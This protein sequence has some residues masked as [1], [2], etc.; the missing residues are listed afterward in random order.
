M[1]DTG[2]IPGEGLPENAGMVEQPGIPA[3]GAYTFL[4]PSE[5]APEDD[6]LLLMPASQGAWSDPQTVQPQVQAQAVPAAAPQGFPAAPQTAQPVAAQA[7]PATAAAEAVQA[8]EA[9]PAVAAAPRPSPPRR[10]RP[11]RLSRSE[12]PSQQLLT[13]SSPY[14]AQPQVPAQGEEARSPPSRTA[15]TSRGAGD[16]GSV[17]LNG[18]RIPPPAPAPAQTA[19]P[20]GAPRRLPPRPAARCTGVRFRPR[21]R[22][23]AAV[24]RAAAWSARWPTGVPAGASGPHLPPATRARR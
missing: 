9:D 8:P 3:P 15:R 2:Q 20:V 18:V 21:L 10:R 24:R 22:R 7:V 16:T 12:Q 13:G 11:H 5:H 4:D 17:D 14:A 23:T 19:A 1:T 6:D